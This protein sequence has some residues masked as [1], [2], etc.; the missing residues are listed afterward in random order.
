[1]VFGQKQRNF[2][3]LKNLVLEPQKIIVVLFNFINFAVFQP[4]I[5][6]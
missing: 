5:E 1:M 4:T 6:K 3:A 2:T